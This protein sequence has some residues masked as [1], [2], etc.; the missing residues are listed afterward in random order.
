M[1]YVADDFVSPLDVLATTTAFFGGKID[2]DPAS[3]ENANTLVAANRFFTPAENGL[4]QTWKANS[5]YLYPPRSVLY[6]AEQPPNTQLFTKH[7]R[8][9][10]SAQRVWVEEALKKY[11]RNEFNEAILFL[12]STEVA[13]ITLQKLNIDFPFCIMKT[14]PR[15]FRDTPALERVRTDKC[16]GFI[17]YMPARI[18]TH[19]R[20]GD[21]IE[22]FS[23]L[24]RVYC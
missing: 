20:V 4:K 24:G 7:K 19:S 17:Y 1:P 16:Y 12:T 22:M 21:F 13:L 9:V 8:F 15:I 2:L 5:L 23:Q 18:D 6:S 14:H 3:S 10:K 11:I